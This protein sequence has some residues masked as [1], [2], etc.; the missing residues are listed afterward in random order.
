VTG[1]IKRGPTGVIGTN[2]HD[3]AQTVA[4][5]LADARAGLLTAPAAGFERLITE[6]VRR[7]LGVDEWSAIDRYEM[8]QGK[9]QRRPRVK[10]TDRQQMLQH[11]DDLREAATPVTTGS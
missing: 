7:P 6:R 5:L 4:S 11:V 2:R 10:L 8:R 9:A 1:W 3:A